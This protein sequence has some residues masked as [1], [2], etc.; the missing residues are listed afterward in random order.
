MTAGKLEDLGGRWRLRF[1]REL[2]HPQDK[3]WRAITEPE[4]MQ[5]W[6]PQH[7]SGEWVVG[8][9]LAFT[10]PEGRGPDFD[11]EVLAYQPQSL[12]EFRWG[13]DVIRLELA[14][15]PDGCTLTLLDTFDEVG[16]AARDA[17][18]WHEC[19]DRL[20]DDLDKG[21]PFVPARPALGR[22]ASALR[23]GVRPRGRRDRPAARLLIQDSR[24][25]S[26]SAAEPGFFSARADRRRPVP[27]IGARPCAPDKLGRSR[28]AQAWVAAARFS[29]A[30]WVSG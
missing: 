20:A 2:A 7:V 19:L 17:A 27:R 8:G 30:V 24:G 4:H 21:E 15:R 3:V 18:G 16:K 25:A 22:S 23:R 14:A 9:P 1:T 10:G 28:E 6:F 13:T 29:R 26:R 11:G 5:A 12:V